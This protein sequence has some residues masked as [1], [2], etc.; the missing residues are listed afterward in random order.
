MRFHNQA[1]VF[2]RNPS[3]LGEYLGVTK[4]SVSQTIA[5]LEE[6][7]LL[8]KKA[9]KKDKRVV[10]LELTAK[11]RK[12]VVESPLQGLIGAVDT[13]DSTQQNE[14]LTYLEQVLLAQLDRQGRKPFGQ[15]QHCR[16][17]CKTQGKYHCALLDVAL[18][19]SSI[20]KNCV[21]FEKP[22]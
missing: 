16:H 3:S 12:V 20:E 11:G 9:D 13:L 7:G 19:E 2:S 10:H 6:R 18:N 15:C 5:T 22:Q 17:N 1:N 14:P 4:G 21:E 8:R